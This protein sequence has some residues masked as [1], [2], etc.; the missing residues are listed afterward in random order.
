M[1]EVSELV[2]ED[3][4]VDHGPDLLTDEREELRLV[5]DTAAEDDDLRAQGHDEGGA[6]LRDVVGL[7]LPY[8]RI[9]LQGDG[10]LAPALL[11]GRAGGHALEAGTMERAVAFVRIVRMLHHRD[12]TELRVEHA[13]DEVTAGEDARTDTSTDRDV[14]R[15]REAARLTV[16]DLT[17]ERAVDIRIEADR[18][19]ERALQCADDVDIGPARLWGRCDIAVGRRVPAKIDRA[20]AGH[21]ERRDLLI[22]EPVDDRGERFLR[23]SRRDGRLLENRSIF[24]AERAHHLR[25]A[26]L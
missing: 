3:V 23:R 4:A 26:G 7:D 8:L 21:T 16:G 24:V 17:E 10:L 14:D 6:G 12:V 18:Y 11:D 25:A 9:V 13:V 22:A 19:A 5:H 20:E 2:G 1:L 15:I